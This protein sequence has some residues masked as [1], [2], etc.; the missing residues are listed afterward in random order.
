MKVCGWILVRSRIMVLAPPL[1][2]VVFI[3]FLGDSA[4]AVPNFQMPFPC[5]EQWRASTYDDHDGIDWNTGDT[6]YA[7]QGRDVV[8]SLSGTATASWSLGFGNYVII[9]H[10]GNWKTIYAHLEEEGVSGTVAQGQKI[11]EVGTTGDSTYP[12]LHWE[13]RYNNV[14]QGTLY[15]NGIAI[16]PG[17]TEVTYTSSNLCGSS[18]SGISSQITTGDVMHVFTG[19]ASGDVYDTSW[20]GGNP[21][22]TW[23][24]GSSLGASIVSIS[25]QYVNGVLH[26]YAATSAG[27]VVDIYWGGGQSHGQKQLWSNSASGN[28]ITSFID[29]GGYQHVEVGTASGY[30]RDLYWTGIYT[31]SDGGV[32]NQLVGSGS[33]LG[34]AVKSLSTQYPGGVVH[35]YA[36]TNA[37]SIVDIYWGGGQSMGQKQLWTNGTSGNVITSFVDT[38][39]YQH[40]EV[41]TASGNVYDLYW[42]G[43]WMGANG[44]VP[45]QLVGN[46]LGA[47]I[48]SVSV[49]Y[50]SEV[51]HVYAMTNAGSLVDIYWGGGQALDQDQKWTNGLSGNSISSQVGAGSVQHVST[52]TSAGNLYDTTW[53]GTGTASTWLVW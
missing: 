29:S 41:G 8:A 33:S 53:N 51:V 30:V 18:L 45:N 3:V 23:K 13:Q 19:T 5:G 48:N 32:P 9:D 49:K 34:S 36:A 2:G 43:V 15:A 14:P 42:T 21:L 25:S 28:V 27:S 37:G 7:D 1:L 6:A 35:V 24:V 4:Y 12:H 47:A 38:S 52:S 17:E 31:G 20:G 40:I 26:V 16:S 50:P 44:G 10:G 22:T 11:G 39:S 46:S